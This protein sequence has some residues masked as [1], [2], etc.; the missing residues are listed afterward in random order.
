LFKRVEIG[1]KNETKI[2]HFKLTFINWHFFLKDKIDVL[3]CSDVMARGM[4]LENVDYVLLYD[5]VPHLNAYVHKVGRTARAGKSGTAISFL[6]HKEIF[7]FK[8]MMSQIN[9]KTVK[10]DEATKS[11]KVSY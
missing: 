4:D 8:K 10:T 1:V 7:F 3:V 5:S 6:E 11:H 2:Y 9:S